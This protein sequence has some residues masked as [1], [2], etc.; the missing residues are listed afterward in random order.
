MVGVALEA[1]VTRKPEV[2]RLV[3]AIR[4]AG[5]RYFNAMTSRELTAVARAL[6][7]LEKGSLVGRVSHRDVPVYEWFAVP[8][9]LLV[10][11]GMTLR[12]LP[13]WIDRT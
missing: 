4:R 5:G 2:R 6:D 9:L 7:A 12:A 13:W 8:A 10:G 3:G 1:A 11:A